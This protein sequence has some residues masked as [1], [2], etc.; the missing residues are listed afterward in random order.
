MKKLKDSSFSNHILLLDVIDYLVDF[1][2]ENFHN[3]IANKEYIGTILLLLKSKDKAILQNKVL[4]LI[5][6]WANKFENQKKTMP[7]FQDSYN[8]LLTSGVLF[9]D[10]LK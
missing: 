2:K 7:I 8:T 6:K 5:K 3:M 1:S 4:Y 10:N 9:Q